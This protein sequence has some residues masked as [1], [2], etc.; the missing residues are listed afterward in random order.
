MSASSAGK[1]AIDRLAPGTELIGD[2]LTYQHH[3]IYLGEGLVIH[4]A[5][6]IRYSHGPIETIPVRNF[7]GRHRV[8]A[9]RR[10]AESVH[11][12]DTVRRALSRLGER[13]YDIFQNNSEHFCSRCQS[14]ESC[15]KQVDFLQQRIQLLKRAAR[16]L[17]MPVA[18]ATFEGDSSSHLR[19][20]RHSSAGHGQRSNQA[21]TSH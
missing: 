11:G 6:R 5:G 1:V 21:V 16:R 14:G 17:L 13:R 9:G 19:G 2:R 4:Y 20:R 8:R 7:V 15:S 10:P 3:G 12:Q 18:K